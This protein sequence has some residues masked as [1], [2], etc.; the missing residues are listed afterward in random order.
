M[1]LIV[2]HKVFILETSSD[3]HDMGNICF[4]RFF[5]HKLNFFFKFYEKN[6]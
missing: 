2:Q 5:Q 1:T 6:E 4:S 3:Y